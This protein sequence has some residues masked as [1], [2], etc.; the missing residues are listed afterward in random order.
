ME[1]PIIIAGREAGR[2]RVSQEGLYT[3]LEGTATGGT[4]AALVR[5]WVHGGGS[6]AY[7]GLMQ[8]Q[9]GA[10]WLRRKLTA[11]ERRA[12]PAP[13]EYA[14]DTDTTDDLHKTIDIKEDAEENS[15]HNTKQ[16]TEN[17]EEKSE[18][19]SLHK[20]ETDLRAC[21]WPAEPAEEGLIW[22]ARGDGSLTAFDGISSLLALPAALRGTNKRAV[23][24]VIEGK[25]YLVFRT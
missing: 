8:P 18:D 16:E 3:V 24:R 20:N 7:L 17:H 15:K 11:L 4:D 9:N 5:L 25:R 12:F 1:L 22:Y 13:M 14:A 6:C 21:P 10:L 23:E 19:R 2:L